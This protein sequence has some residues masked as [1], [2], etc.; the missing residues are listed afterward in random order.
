M[1]TLIFF[2]HDCRKKMHKTS[3]CGSNTYI[4]HNVLKILFA[5]LDKK[6]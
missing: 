2:S 4:K 6:M 1:T 3:Q 5:K